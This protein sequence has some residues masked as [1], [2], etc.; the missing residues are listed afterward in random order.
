M[1]YVLLFL[2]FFITFNPN[3]T[4]SRPWMNLAML[5]NL[6]C[7]LEVNVYDICKPTVH[8]S[9]LWPI[10]S[11]L[12]PILCSECHESRWKLETLHSDKGITQCRPTCTV[13]E[14]ANSRGSLAVQ[15]VANHVRASV[16][17][18]QNCWGGHYRTICSP[19]RYRAISFYVFYSFTFFYCKY[20]PLF[21]HQH[22]ELRIFNGNKNIAQD[23]AFYLSGSAITC[24]EPSSKCDWSANH[25]PA[26]TAH[27]PNSNSWERAEIQGPCVHAALVLGPGWAFQKMNGW[28]GCLPKI[29]LHVASLWQRGPQ[30]RV[31]SWCAR[32]WWPFSLKGMSKQVHL[33]GF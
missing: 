9:A 18:V 16:S 33:V 12:L 19:Y 5:A 29:G 28:F 1:F 26:R 21:W 14:L 17:R 8:L 27:E 10:R 3:E 4:W 7:Y 31:T 11:T 24:M 20:L 13:I 25:G 2:E 23:D 15:E 6:Q 32:P 22:L 30:N